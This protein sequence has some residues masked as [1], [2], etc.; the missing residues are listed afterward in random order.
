MRSWVEVAHS[1]DRKVHRR[2]ADGTV[3]RAPRTTAHAETLSNVTRVCALWMA[4]ARSALSCRTCQ[5]CSNSIAKT[6]H[7]L[8][9]SGMAS[10]CDIGW[11]MGR[12]EIAERRPSHCSAWRDM[13][14]FWVQRVMKEQHLPPIDRVDVVGVQCTSTGP[15]RRS[16]LVDSQSNWHGRDRCET[17]I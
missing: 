8:L 14:D 13:F 5:H 2:A 17:S 9:L 12:H 15:R 4:F 6:H 10:S 1:C 16:G 7:S 11:T 3:E